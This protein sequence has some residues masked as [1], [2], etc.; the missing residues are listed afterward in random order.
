[1]PNDEVLLVKNLFVA[2]MHSSYNCFEPKPSSTSE[3]NMGEI[4]PESYLFQTQLPAFIGRHNELEEKKQDTTW[5]I[6]GGFVPQSAPLL[7]P[8]TQSVDWALRTSEA[9]N[10]ATL[11]QRYNPRPLLMPET[12]QKTMFRF[13]VFFRSAVPLQAYISDKV[14]V[15]H[16]QKTYTNAPGL[17]GD[18]L[19]HVCTNVAPADTFS[20][21]ENHK[22]M[23]SL[24]SDAI[25]GVFKA[26]QVQFGEEIKEVGEAKSRAIYSVDVQFDETKKKVQILGFSF[27]PADNLDYNQAFKALFFDEVADLVAV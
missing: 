15:L 22:V 11:V 23:H 20:K 1:M 3:I 13:S 8:I 21:I 18:E 25:R 17:F 5:Q 12:G 16:A 4:V 26:F 10:C 24:A 7:N 2:L 9:G 14:Q 6:V 27:A 19:I